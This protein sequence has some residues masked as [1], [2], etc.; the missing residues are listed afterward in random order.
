MAFIPVQNLH[1]F[2]TG[3]YFSVRIGILCVFCQIVRNRTKIV[4]LYL[5][6]YLQ[7]NF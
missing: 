5:L 2:R 4:Q 3:V 7:I 6:V 1:D